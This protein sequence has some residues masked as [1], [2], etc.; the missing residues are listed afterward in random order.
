[1]YHY[2]PFNFQTT[3]TTSNGC[4]NNGIQGTSYAAPVA[5]AIVA[6]TLEAK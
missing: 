4:T 6:L 3:T 5:S 1:M 2:F